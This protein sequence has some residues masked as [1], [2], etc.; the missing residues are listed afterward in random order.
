L[1]STYEPISKPILTSPWTI[2][3]SEKLYRLH[4]WGEPYFSINAAGHVTVSPQGDR[5][6]SLDLYELVKSLRQRNLDTP[7]LIRFSDI[8][9]DRL[10]RLNACFAKAIARYQYPNVYRGVFPIKCNQHRH[11][12]ETLVKAGKPH[13][14]GLEVGS[15]PELIIALATL[16]PASANSDGKNNPLLICNGYKDA[17]YFETALLATRLGQQPIIV[18]EQP[19]ELPLLLQVSQQL[20]ITP[21]IGV[22]AKLRTKGIG[23]WGN[24]TGDRAKFGLTIP[25]ILEVIQQLQQADRLDC[26]Q[27]LHF[28]IGSQISAISVI[29]DAIREASQIYGELVQLGAKMGY[30]D[31]GGGLAVDY[32]GSKT[33]LSSSKNYNLQNYAN[34]IVAEVK[35]AC[36]AK[37]I[38]APIL[39]SESGRAIASHQS[40]LVF[41]ILGTSTPPRDSLP[42][43]KEDEHLIVRNLWETYTTINQDNC[44]ET[45]H[46][47][48]QFKDEAISLFNF[49]YLSLTERAKVEQLYWACCHKIYQLIQNQEGVSEDLAQL[50]QSMAALYYGNFSVFQSIP[51]AWAID[52]LFPILPIH[53]LNTEP[54]QRG[55]IVDLTC[56][57]DGRLDQ[58]IAGREPK[59]FLELH[60]LEANEEYYLGIFLVGAYQEIMGNLHN[61]FGDTN[62]VHISMTPQGYKLDQVVKGDT[63]EEVLSYAQ[64]D[65]EDLVETIRQ[66]TEQALQHNQITLAESQRLLQN[67]E[68][69][70]TRYTYLL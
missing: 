49:G 43:V 66:R 53:R 16:E 9:A 47:A 24:S 62:V 54:T 26:L 40:V 13:Q 28:H 21:T 50:E 17:E 19:E 12:V 6:G 63:I 31:V 41:D 55:V 5:G 48:I 38:P 64:Y 22:R 3:D 10:E 60:S 20:Q 7:I 29:K 57:S 11:L 58:F 30:L 70:L 8:L 27:L 46:D 52:Q 18:I 15:K 23:R 45:Y 25:Q 34:D 2:E 67:Y 4:S 61:L 35:E 59:E 69:S 51:D 37:R 1:T 44:Q 39:I 56:D 65:S 36:E 42:P 68:N 33:N 32:D 14:F